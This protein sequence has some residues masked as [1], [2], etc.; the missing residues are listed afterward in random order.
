M[1]LGSP[2]ARTGRRLAAVV[3]GSGWRR[4]PLA[5][6]LLLATLVPAAGRDKPSPIFALAPMEE[7][8]AGFRE[9]G[10]V[11]VD[12]AGATYLSD[13]EAGTV[14]HLSPDGLRRILVRRLDKPLGLALDRD[15]GLLIAEAGQDRLLRR[16]PS[17]ALSVLVS[18]IKQPRWLAVAEDG[19][20]YITARGLRGD[21]RDH[22]EGDE[23]DGRGEVI[24]R[25]GAD[26]RLSVAADG[27]KG[28]QGIGVH[29]QALYAASQRRHGEGKRQASNLVRFPIQPDGSLGLMEVLVRGQLLNPMGLAI[30]ALGGVFITAERLHGEDERDGD[31]RDHGRQDDDD[32]TGVILKWR[33][34]GRLVTFATG[35][36]R[37]RGL[38]LETLGGLL[39]AEGRRLLRL[40]APAPP[41]VGL[42][43]F[44]NQ[45]LFT[46][47]GTTEPH[48]R[49][50][51]VLN[52]A[53]SPLTATADAAGAFSLVVP[54]ALDSE[55]QF[56]IFATALGGDGLS[57]AAAEARLTH[58]ALRP[59]LVFQSPVAGALVRGLVPVHAQASDSG[60]G[61]SSLTLRADGQ[62]LTATLTPL[63]PDPVITATAT[64][65]TTTLPDGPH[66]LMAAATD[67]AGNSQQATRNVIV[68]N[69]PPETKLTG[70]PSGEITQ[71]SATFTFAGTD[72]LT[73]PERLVFAWRLD[74]GPF[75]DFS[76]STTVTLTGLAEGPHI[77]RVK[78][79]DQ[80][81]NED[82]TPAEAA[83]TVALR[84]PAP[85]ITGFSPTTA[86]LGDPVTITGTNFDPNPTGNQV[87][88][89]GV[90]ASVSAATATRLVVRV[91]A[92]AGTGPLAVT[93]T[94]G[95]AQ[96]AT[97]LTVIMMT[98]LAVTPAQATLPIDLTQPFRGLATFS[99]QRTSDV[100]SFMSWASS[101]PDSVTV[102]AAGLA[103]GLAFG[104]AT[105][106]GT[107]GNLRGAATVQVI[108]DS[109]GGP[110]PPD[111]AVVAPSLDPT[112][113]TTLGQ[114]T[115]FLYTGAN[116]IQT[117]VAPG[118]ITVTRA[119]V[120][121]GTVRGRDG[122][123]IPGVT[124]T[125]LNHPEFGQ[126]LTRP[127]GMFDLAVNGGGQLT[128][129]YAKLG[130]LPVQ[131]QVNV[132]WQDYV[133]VADVV[134]SALDPQVTA[135][136]LPGAT[137]TQVARGS[138]VA[139]A[140]GTRQATLL[141]AP[142]TAATMTLP[143][144][145]TQ[146]LTTL[147]VRATEYT[148]GTTGPQ[149]MPAPLPPNSLYTYAVSYSVDEALNAGA[150]SVQFTQPV[151]AYVENFLGLPVGTTIPAGSYDRSRGVWVGSANGQ[152]IQV[153]SVSDG[154]ASVDTNGDGAADNLLGLSTAELQQLGALY[155]PGAS[156]WRVPVTHFS[157][158]DYN[159]GP[160]FPPRA[161]PPS[162]PFAHAVPRVPNQCEFPQQSVIG[163]QNQTLAET[164]ALTGAPFT[165]H[166]QSDRVPGRLAADALKI[167][168]SGAS[169]PDPLKRIDVEVVVAGRRFTRSFPPAPNQTFTFQWDGKD[170]YGRTPQGSFT[171]QVGVGYVYDLVYG[172]TQRW[173]ANGSTP[174]LTPFARRI[175]ATQWQRRAIA[176]T[177]WDARA[178]GLGGWSLSVHHA[179]DPVAHALYLGT[180]GQREADTL[181]PIMTT[182]LEGGISPNQLAAGPDG[183]VYIASSESNRVWRLT[184]GGA[185]STVAGTGTAGF[186]GDGGPATSAQLFFPQGVALGLDGSVYVAD[187][188]N[189]RV[190]RVDLAGI[191]TT[192]AG[193]GVAGGGG[194]NGA[195]P[196][197]QLNQ[198]QGVA[199]GSDGS[200]YIADTGN[201]RIR[202]L[203]PDGV[204]A[205]YAGTGSFSY[206]GD[207][208]PALAATMRGPSQVAVAPDGS[209]YIVDAT[210]AMV[211]RVGVDGLIQAV[212][213][214]GFFCQIP[215]YAG[216][217][218][219]AIDAHTGARGV[220]VGPDG[221]VYVA[222]S[223]PTAGGCCCEGPPSVGVYQIDPLGIIRRVAGTGVQGFSGDG[224]PATQALLNSPNGVAVSPDGS[225]YIADNGNR[226]V[227]RVTAPLPGLGVSD[228]ILAS[229]DGGELYTFN[230][231]GKHL[232]TVDALTGAVK[233]Q[234]AYDDSGLL[235][236]V[237]DVAGQ[238]TTIERDGS[239]RPTAIVAPGGQRTTLVVEANGYLT[240]IANPAGE[241]VALT[242]GADGLLATQTN[243]RGFT[244]QYSYDGQGLLT[245]DA[246]PAG[247]FSALS[248]AE[249]NTSFT[250]SLTS[251]LNRTRSYFTEN[252]TTGARHQ[253]NTDAAGLTTDVVIKADGSL[254]ITAPDGTVTTSIP[255]PDPR[256]G[257]QAPITKSL[258]VKLPG[259]LTSTL[260]TTRTATLTNPAD[261]LNLTAQTDTLVINGR[262]YTSTYTQATRLL[263][264]TTPAGRTSTVTLD[265]K[266]RVVQEQVAGLEAVS[267]TYDSLGRLSTIT[268]GS[269]QDART[270]TLSYNTKN[271]LISIKDPL[272]RTV[273]FIYDVAGRITSQTLPDLREI[274]YTYDANGNVTSLTP[275]GSPAHTFSYTPVDLEESYTPPDLGFAPRQTQ[276][277]YNVNRQLDL[278]TRPDGQTIELNYDTA[279]R[280]ST[281]II[282]TGTVQYTYSPTT[283][284]LASI[285]APGSTLNYAYDGSLL[286]SSTWDGPVTGNVARI[287]DNNL[288]TASQSVNGTNTITFGY[289]NDSFL[290]NAGA[291][292]ITRS[293]QHGL[294]TE[295]TLGT[296]TDSRS[297][298]SFGELSIYT[299]QASDTPV[300]DIQYTRDKLGRITRK[301][302]TIG[303]ITDTFDYTYDLAGRLTAAKKNGATIATYSYDSNGN[304]LSRTTPDGTLSGS[305]DAQD[306]LTQYGS[307]VYAYTPNGELQAKTVSGQTTT[308]QYDVLGN[309]LSVMEPT[310]A[311][312]EYV[313]DGQNRR[314]GKKLNGTLVQALLYQNQLNVVAEL[315]G[316][317]NVV[318]RFVYG[319][320]ANVPDYMIKD[321]ISYRIVSDHL[322]S[323]RLVI[324]TADGT[325]AQ[326]L[327]FDEFGNVLQDTNSGFQPFGFAGGLYDQHTGLLRFGV[328]DYDALTGRWAAKDSIGFTEDVTN[329]YGYV[330]NDPVNLVDLTGLKH[331]WT[332]PQ[333]GVLEFTGQRRSEEEI[334]Q[335]ENLRRNL[336]DI[337]KPVPPLPPTRLEGLI[338]KV[339][340]IKEKYK[341]EADVDVRKFRLKRFMFEF[342][343]LEFS[344]RRCGT[345]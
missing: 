162:G 266:G 160:N 256:F 85:T 57:S 197:A 271:E 165:L 107:L 100:T 119:A 326:R 3:F 318:S 30:D 248:R 156:L 18:G 246:D 69:T 93:T 176:P 80:A 81:G 54:L 243:A 222:G 229:E 104:A 199:V 25:L 79:H 140:D 58:D 149:A 168:L 196:L 123:P 99:D 234:F 103:Q 62:P 9:P 308:Y 166:Y 53:A 330:L 82:L 14:T 341:L 137:T 7:V 321:G 290:T 2:L 258:S 179:Y 309:L 67:R 202:R 17:G 158:Y 131:R 236:S 127:D 254:T 230:N 255:G 325:I 109:G 42:P 307:T 138:A 210:N 275:P 217:G 10:G 64:L 207:G 322:G 136:T 66:T 68:D 98:A 252:L 51:L 13:R 164:V 120:V 312:I 71:T 213:K 272:D 142:G 111:P 253:V 295:T 88:I 143:G 55:N 281:L 6:L 263:N 262:T 231:V 296:V 114:A 313:I 228:F 300:V 84:L 63:P 20:V 288:R 305:Y 332:N 144:G 182:A 284:N 125:I 188:Q 167:P 19:G 60:S 233:Y 184:P 50:D 41:T 36:T 32:T 291:L 29:S 241:T 240:T 157:E 331:R 336:E 163:C 292:T 323:P 154:V 133:I 219:P 132:P 173:G 270:S 267:Y 329:L 151:S 152:I 334:Q 86:R 181:P 310:G 315:D 226:R 169:V 21:R 75:T 106:T 108:T 11:L 89:G 212:T 189:H 337:M 191:I 342:K 12:E 23:D 121:R 22:D 209:L 155:Q 141:F 129:N 56:T 257:M 45:S 314:I 289:D 297:Y 335:E 83:F 180:G 223:S 195:A 298:N 95:T 39:V 134:M 8:A 287:Y 117:G 264:T 208:G 320:K 244:S 76:V 148:V 94:G 316:S 159:F 268:L 52:E 343:V 124:V 49:L 239:G 283:G 293:P 146:P 102:S 150:T 87:T 178:Q 15:G 340:E 193:T 192:V 110:L 286:T 294:I 73:L 28:L 238:V 70:G 339:K 128:V 273:G 185:V 259:G 153:L 215:P 218:G 105:V 247:G 198:P 235:A 24:L 214:N 225:L 245:R 203:G 139:D 324:N 35:L 161:A 34:D 200:V 186:S 26:G 265:T 135:V 319:T 145:G 282:P 97:P 327:D 279:G 280:V 61:V 338:E 38:A 261:P 130:F 147:N 224:G 274:H 227:R 96:S 277:T 72:N 194:D 216:D 112:V 1:I 206:S 251:A 91:P 317:G 249:N 175:E 269:G 171:Y 187:T 47:R 328:R 301:V 260:T 5:G 113:A 304:R 344:G 250:V 65:N 46:V 201:N 92:G 177:R 77:F 221:T 4:I 16:E 211:R 204:L 306:R 90:P 172:S 285:T 278:V 232:H 122:F 101:N 333:T 59:S 302:E 345:W 170:A 44:T 40:H 33:P 126:T 174:P 78:A 220:T 303:G 183:S 311:V 242:Y 118:T 237:T 190:R 74:G 43:P 115:A 31:E 48:A 276:Y 27:F 37:P 116:P 299:A 205:A